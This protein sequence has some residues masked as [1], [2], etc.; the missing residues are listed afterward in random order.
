MAPS[1][2]TVSYSTI[3]PGSRP[4]R[5][6]DNDPTVSC[7]ENLFQDK[8]ADNAVT[9]FDIKFEKENY[10]SS[11]PSYMR[12]L[13]FYCTDFRNAT[14]GSFVWWQKFQNEANFIPRTW[15]YWIG[16]I[17]GDCNYFINPYINFY[18]REAAFGSI[19]EVDV[20]RGRQLE[21]FVDSTTIYVCFISN[22][23]V[24][25]KKHIRNVLDDFLYC[26]LHYGRGLVADDIY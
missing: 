22:N 9:L 14:D 5:M 7:Y 24:A 4:T 25:R 21:S 26:L 15:K 11:I 12:D 16:D 10:D 2:T 19:K 6:E 18:I 20:E 17:M 23:G 1:S 13:H 3:A 8:C